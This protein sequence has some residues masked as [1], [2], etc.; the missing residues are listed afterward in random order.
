[1]ALIRRH[2][3]SYRDAATGRIL[4]TDHLVFE[5]LP[6]LVMGASVVA[7]V[8]LAGEASAAILAVSGLLSA[9]LFAVMLQVFE[10]AMDLADEPPGRGAETS[11]H[12]LFL[13]EISANAG[14]AALVAIA[15][16]VV[17]LVATAV[18]KTALTIAT[19]VA[20]AL[21]THLILVLLMVMNRVYRLTEERLIT[22]R[23]TS[24]VAALPDRR[25]AG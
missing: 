10:R 11:R 19:G 8:Q 6:A 14:Y 21:G 2:Y 5:G 25:R 9:F 4:W 1:M 18:S 3:D 7:G 20:L 12:A 24:K 15:T 22:A 16:A 13:G 17:A 23:T